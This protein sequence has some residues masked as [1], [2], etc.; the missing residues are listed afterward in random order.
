VDALSALHA[1]DVL[2]E[3]LQ[4]D[5]HIPDPVERAG[6]DAVINATAR[7]LRDS[8]EEALYRRMLFLAESRKLVGPIQVL[9][10]MR[11]RGALPCLV[12]ALEDDL[13][14][15]VAEDA[16]RSFGVEAAAVLKQAARP[17]TGPET[18]SARR[19]RRAALGLLDEIRPPPDLP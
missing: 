16:L 17:G 7:A 4:T 8:T 10:A 9:G 2:A 11:R 18:E 14:R 15:P 19:R 3:F 12:A 1:T 6:E 5:R 13:A